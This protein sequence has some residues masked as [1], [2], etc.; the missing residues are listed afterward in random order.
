MG[1]SSAITGLIPKSAGGRM[2]LGTSALGVAAGITG[3]KKRSSGRNS[4]EQSM[5]EFDS[6]PYAQRKKL[7]VDA[8]YG[9]SPEHG[10]YVKRRVDMGNFPS[11]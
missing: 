11:L 10:D 5:N 9:V 3:Y 2:A 8:A 7:T 1:M 6:L 4:I